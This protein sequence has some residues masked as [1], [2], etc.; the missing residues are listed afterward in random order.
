MKAGTSA[1]MQLLVH[2]KLLTGWPEEE[3]ADVFKR[4]HVAGLSMI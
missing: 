1:L 2:L 4:P 3:I